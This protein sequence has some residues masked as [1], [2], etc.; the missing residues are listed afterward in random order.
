M[1]SARAVIDGPYAL[2]EDRPE[3][4]SAS[5][6][7]P[8]HAAHWVVEVKGDWGGHTVSWSAVFG[9]D[10]KTTNAVAEAFRL[11]LAV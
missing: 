5:I 3:P 6:L 1:T 10:R 4:W 7:T 11:S 2:L 8:R 9:S